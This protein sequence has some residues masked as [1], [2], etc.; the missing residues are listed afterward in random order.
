MT[1]ISWTFERDPFAFSRFYPGFLQ[2]AGR[3]M[4]FRVNWHQLKFKNSV[5]IGNL[6]LRVFL[7]V[8]IVRKIL[9]RIMVGI[10]REF[11]GSFKVK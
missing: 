9:N 8:N 5:N 2:T 11:C 1:V 10:W 4:T 6:N 3:G 7:I